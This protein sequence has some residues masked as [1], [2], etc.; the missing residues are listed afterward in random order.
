MKVQLQ[1]NYLW[2]ANVYLSTGKASK[3]QKLF[4]KLLKNIPSNELSQI[5]VAGDFNINARDNK[6]ELTQ[7]LSKLTKQMGFTLEL[8]DGPTRK[9]ATLDFMLRG[10]NISVIRGRCLQSLSDH[11]AIHWTIDGNDPNKLKSLK[12]LSR[13]IAEDI[14][15]RL[16][17]NP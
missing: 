9:D 17:T 7:F 13:N 5:I 8:P 10:K 6:N 12:I 14:T 2:L 1:N 11:K 15:T 3:L 4:G 16:L